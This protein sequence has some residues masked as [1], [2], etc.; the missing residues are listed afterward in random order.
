MKTLCII[1]LAAALAGTLPCAT[2][3][4]AAEPRAKKGEA[5]AAAP[6]V[7]YGTVNI[8]EHIYGKKITADDLRGRVVFFEYWGINCPPCRAS[9]PHLQALY[10]SLGKTGKFVILGAH[11]QAAGDAVAKFL[12]DLKITF[13][14]YQSPV[15]KE[16]PCPGGIP[17]AVLVN[18][19]GTIVR[20][21]SPDTLYG[22]VAGLVRACPDPASILSSLK[23]QHFKSL[24]GKAIPGKT[25][26]ESMVA[27][28][29]KKA[30]G[31]GAEAEE[32]K[33]ICARVDEWLAAEKAR[34][35]QSLAQS[36]SEAAERIT[37]LK[38]SAPTVTEFDGKL[39]GLKASPSVQALCG[40][41][42]SIGQ[43]QAK[44]E[45][46]GRVDLAAKAELARL[47]KKLAEL[48]AAPGADAA[49]RSEADAMTKEIDALAK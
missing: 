29:R 27:P 31:T 5:A 24:Q 1:G 11:S 44:I 30:E 2:S 26:L 40:V 37:A 19:D 45:R 21:G 23:I 9:M 18:Y 6:T 43:V 41:R 10:G 39:T 42:K 12:A 15:L 7:D 48:S 32:A 3:A 8:S 33:L 22:E 46:N 38:F 49:V 28:L 47:Q 16:A 35:T 20:K 13:P 14:V 17:Y 4:N 25:N 34:I 36:P